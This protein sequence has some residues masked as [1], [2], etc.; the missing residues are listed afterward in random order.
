M[1][2]DLRMLFTST[3]GGTVTYFENSLPGVAFFPATKP[4]TLGTGVTGALATF[5]NVS[6]GTTQYYTMS[7]AIPSGGMP[8]GSILHFT[9]GRG[10]ARS[11][12]TGGTYNAVTNSTTGSAYYV[13]DIFGGGVS[14]PSGTVTNAGMT[15]SGT[16]A[17]GGTFSGTI[18]NVLG[19]GWA[20]T[21][22]YGFVNAQQAATVTTVQ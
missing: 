12:S 4:F 15:F 10:L 17:D 19:S 16:T 5:S 21:D 20:K 13:A 18:T 14:L 9:V 6:S 1:C 11:A 22:G 3:V 8:G 7:I 2:S